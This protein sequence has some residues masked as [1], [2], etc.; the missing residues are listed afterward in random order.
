MAAE[1]FERMIKNILVPTDYSEASL[2]ALESAVL[3]AQRNNGHLQI[4][5][6][7][8]TD[9]AYLGPEQLSIPE[10]ARQV[11]EAMSGSIRQKHGFGPE[12]IFQEGFA[13]P[14]IVKTAFDRKADLIVIGAHGASGMREQ[15][16]G[17]TAYYVIK[18]ANCPVLIIPEGRKWLGFKQI[19]FPLRTSFGAFKRYE[20]IKAMNGG[21]AASLE[22][23]A[24]SVEKGPEG[25]AQELLGSRLNPA[26]SPSIF[27]ISLRNSEQKNIAREVLDRADRLPADLI[28][29]SPAVDVINKQFFIGPF[30]QRIIHHAKVPLLYVR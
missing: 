21:Q 9:T 19:L 10:H 6:V 13:G 20:F 26:G 4:L 28:V 29:L 11:T 14:A 30:C 8:E 16:I 18:Y 5:H 15:F 24:L 3:I 12:A 2:N 25:Y 17:S 27:R 23:L 22:I 1:P 7:G